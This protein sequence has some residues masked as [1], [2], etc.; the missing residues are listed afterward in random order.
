MR[1]FQIFFKSRFD[2]HSAKGVLK[3]SKKH[4]Q[5]F[6]FFFSLELLFVRER[7]KTQIFKKYIYIYIFMK[8]EK[9][10]PLLRKKTL[11]R[12]GSYHSALMRSRKFFEKEPFLLGGCVGKR[13]F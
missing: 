13:I 8:Q 4:T 1:G 2:L 11:A 12:C 7:E 5:A 6:F 9:N 3:I 10:V